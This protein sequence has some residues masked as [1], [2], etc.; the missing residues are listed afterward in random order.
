MVVRFR[1]EHVL[2]RICQPEYIVSRDYD[3]VHPVRVKD[4]LFSKIV[5]LFPDILEIR[6]SVVLRAIADVPRG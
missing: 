3:L 4:A 1:Y 2:L 6:A 5:N